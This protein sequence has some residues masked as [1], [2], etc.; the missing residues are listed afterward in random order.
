MR[1][2]AELSGFREFEQA[3]L[4]IGVFSQRS[5]MR[6][7]LSAAATPVLRK[8]RARAPTPKIRR[9][10]IKKLNKKGSKLGEFTVSVLTRKAFNPHT[11]VGDS[12][13]RP[14]SDKDAFYSP[15]YEFGSKTIN[16]QAYIG[17]AYQESQGE[18]LVAFRKKY[19]DAINKQQAKLAARGRKK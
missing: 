1:I 4:D 19:F 13:I 15:W 14:Y 3:L 17:P 10:T 11:G 18:A 12:K 8:A 16:Q 5:A 6:A 2:N 7:A 9:N